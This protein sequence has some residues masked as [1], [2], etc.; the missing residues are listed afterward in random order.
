MTRRLTTGRFDTREELTEAVHREWLHSPRNLVQIAR[1]CQ[2]SPTTVS[3]IL[4]TPRL[5]PATQGTTMNFDA[6]ASRIEQQFRIMSQHELFT[7]AI[8]GD[9]VWAQY[10]AA[11][12]EGTN[13]IYRVRTT[14]DCSCCRNFIKNLGNVV[15]I[16]DGE[17]VSVWHAEGLDEIYGTVAVALG[18]LVA[19]A[20]INGVFRAREPKYGEQTTYELTKECTLRWDHLHAKIAARHYAGKDRERILGEFTGIQ[21]VFKRGLEE[22]KP[23]ALDTVLELINSNALYRG[24]E[25]KRAVEA[26]HGLHH[27][28]HNLQPKQREMLIWANLAHP[29]A[30]FR[31][32]V[33]GTLVQDLSEGI[34]LERAVKSF[35]TKVAPTNYKRPTALITPSMVKD[36]MQT[37]KDLGLEPALERRFAKLSDVSVNDVLWVDNALR[38]QMKGGL[39]SL[40]LEAAKALIQSDRLKA[41]DISMDDFTRTVLPQVTA[42]DVFMRNN[43]QGNLMSITAPVHGDGSSLF[44][45]DNDFAWSYNGNITDSIKERVKSA[46]GKVDSRLR[47]SLGWFNFDDLDLH[48]D[49]PL[50]HIYFGAKGGSNRDRNILD[51]DMNAGTGHSREPVENLA[52]DRLPKGTYHVWVNQFRQRERD[53]VGFTVEIESGDELQQYNYDRIIAD[54][55]QVQICTFHVSDTSI[56]FNINSELDEGFAGKDVWGITTERFLKV[57]TLMMSPNYW[58]GQQIGNKH[59]FFLLDGCKNPDAA[60][61]IYNEFLDSRLDKHR[62]VFEI[63]GDKTK[64]AVTD[65][66]LSG[67]GFSSTRGD[68][69][70]VNVTGPKLRKLYNIVF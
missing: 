10:L 39:E 58:D 45:W 67:L 32:T 11:F 12:P 61:G 40:L 36:A 4:D 25:H 59:W 16:I 7:V 18:T 29:A 3:K 13:P 17:V 66:Q 35:E 8:P 48:C 49:G 54:K 69:V 1:Y 20:P 31:N 63:L 6:F 41:E 43:Q 21:Q 24:E 28:Y 5:K 57:N 68:T 56:K 46:G 30:R 52:F 34:E 50:G 70:L 51:V 23:E 22:L 14:H 15:A 64:C 53:N 33:I 62:K 27:I 44:K 65:E 19:N 38:S 9:E 47:I 60:R 2:V 42:M 26:F 55:D 37:I